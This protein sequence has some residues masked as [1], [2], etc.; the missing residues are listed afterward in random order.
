MGCPSSSNQPIHSG[1]MRDKGVVPESLLVQVAGTQTE[2]DD[3]DHSVR[4]AT[5]VVRL[6]QQ[7]GVS[8]GPQEEVLV[9]KIAILESKDGVGSSRKRHCSSGPHC[10]RVEARV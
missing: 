8:F 9:Q 4:E 10:G 3:Y 6:G 2:D 1:K 7:I 5:E